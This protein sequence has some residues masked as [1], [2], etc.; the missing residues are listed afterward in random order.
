MQA[1]VPRPVALCFVAV[2]VGPPPLAAR[3]DLLTA[4]LAPD[5]AAESVGEAPGWRLAG[6]LPLDA[7]RRERWGLSGAWV[8]P[9]GDLRALGA[10]GHDGAPG[11]QVNRGLE[12]RDDG[13][14]GHQGVDLC[15]RHAGGIV[16]AA[17]SGLVVRASS[18][19]QN[20]YGHFVVIAHRLEEGTMVYSVYA[21]LAAGSIR[22][23]EG[24][25]I[26]AGAEI[27]RVGRT[28]RATTDHLHFEVRRAE[29]PWARWEKAPIE[30]PVAFVTAHLAPAADTTWAGPYLDWA[31]CAAIVPSIQESG[32]P[33]E[34]GDWWLML[35]RSARQ[36]AELGADRDSLGARL[37]RTGLV[38]TVDD[39]RDAPPVTWRELAQDVER[40]IAVGLRLPPCPVSLAAHR[41]ACARQFGLIDPAHELGR[42]A[43]RTA[44]A[45]TRS[46]A[47]LILADLC[48]RPRPRT[49]P[50]P[51]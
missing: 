34:R 32:R 46:D 10:A 21:H 3:A 40:L 15:N 33:L 23:H 49:V 48:L 12:T 29:D 2:L 19:D 18:V 5:S 31:A 6:L 25:M 11:Y 4:S 47:C 20:G 14:V 44:G 42:I 24:E 7:P 45:P 26:S 43:K 30:D 39:R 36:D 38:P 51:R 13:S 17:A 27:G 22:V 1:T 37:V 8:F 35:A 41:A 28:G 16:R 9:V 50:R